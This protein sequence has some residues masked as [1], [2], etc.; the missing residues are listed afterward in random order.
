M[1]LG[2]ECRIVPSLGRGPAIQD[3]SAL[4]VMQG[5]GLYYTLVNGISN[6]EDLADKMGRVTF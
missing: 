1:Y 5:T 2:T 3:V 6:V 4:D